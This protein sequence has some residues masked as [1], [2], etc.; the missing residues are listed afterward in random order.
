MKAY[1]W[2]SVVWCVAFSF[3]VPAAAQLSGSGRMSVPSGFGARGGFRGGGFGG[4]PSARSGLGA[5]SNPAF[6]PRPSLTPHEVLNPSGSL[7]T[8][9]V[10]NPE[11][12]LHRPRSGGMSSRIGA[13]P[14]SPDRSSIS[15]NAMST[16]PFTQLRRMLRQS[17]TELTTA[18]DQHANGDGWKAYLSLGALV[19]LQ[20]KPAGPPDT[21]TAVHL[22]KTLDRYK[23][24]ETDEKYQSVS[25]LPAF[26]EVRV[27]LNRYLTPAAERDRRRLAMNW[28]RLSESLGGFTSGDRWKHYLVLPP[29]VFSPRSA[30][31]PAHV[32]ID[33]KQLK[34]VLDR[35]DR[36]AR[37]AKYKKI[38]SLPA[39]RATHQSLS[40]YAAYPR[41][42]ETG[43]SQ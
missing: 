32:Q 7:S 17:A 10:L 18:L 12:S 24:T 39:F 20:D 35:Y 16:M 2:C 9:Q 19:E 21:E 26:R 37:D 42:R 5:R 34:Q 41:I 1:A 38:T 3:A 14:S 36:V 4:S 29:G 22:K 15:S 6:N 30:S 27:V 8:G 43:G 25:Q 23:A 28:Q 31:E 33:P 40:D 11:P 13:S